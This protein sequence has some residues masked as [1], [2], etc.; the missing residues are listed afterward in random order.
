MYWRT[1]PRVRRA[2]GERDSRGACHEG[3]RP[4]ADMHST[5]VQRLAGRGVHQREERNLDCAELFR[6]AA[7]L[8][9]A[10]LLGVRL[11]RV[12]TVGR[13]EKV[14]AEYIRNQERMDIQE[15]RQL[16]LGF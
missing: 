2:E 3:P 12:S 15:D 10:A 1:V 9:W 6:E 14:I 8:H 7:E 13:D 16:G 5:Q 4:H 11:L